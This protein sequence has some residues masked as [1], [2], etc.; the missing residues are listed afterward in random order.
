MIRE[1]RKVSIDQR[2]DEI[3]KAQ[4]LPKAELDQI[5]ER[6]EANVL[7]RQIERLDEW[8]EKNNASLEG[9]AAEKA[10]GAGQGR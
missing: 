5:E 2:W 10:V 6:A 4:G 1:T 7:T 3:E 9:Q 8:V